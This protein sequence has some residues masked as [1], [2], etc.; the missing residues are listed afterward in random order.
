MAETPEG[1][2]KLSAELLVFLERSAAAEPGS[3][4]VPNPLSEQELGPE[5]LKLL[6]D[7]MVSV[8]A[9]RFHSWSEVRQN[10]LDL[11]APP[12]R[13]PAHLRQT[14]TPAHIEFLRQLVPL[15][16]EAAAQVCSGIDIE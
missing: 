11:F 4:A 7:S 9:D 12:A 2:A 8:F 3:A 14:V 5:R 6:A 10:C 16:R 15:L 13:D 1:A